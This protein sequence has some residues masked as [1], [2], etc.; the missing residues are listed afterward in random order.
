MRTRKADR[1]DESFIRL[2]GEILPSQKSLYCGQFNTTVIIII[3]II[4]VLFLEC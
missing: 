3:I 4:I 1:L 2:F